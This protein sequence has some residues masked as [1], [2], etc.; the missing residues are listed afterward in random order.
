MPNF[1]KHLDEFVG[2]R[3]LLQ[4]TLEGC[5]ADLESSRVEGLNIEAAQVIIQQVSRETQEQ[6]KFHI[7]SIVSMALEAV[8]DEPYKFKVLFE[9]KRNQTEA[10]CKFERDGELI[11]PMTATGG[12][13][14]DVASF[15]L[16]VTLW[17][18]GK[19]RST[20]IL[21]EPF[22]F[23]SQD[24][25]PRAGA[26]I[27]ELSDKLGIQ[28]IVVTHSQIMV[29]AADKVLVARLKNGRSKVKEQQ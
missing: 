1:R 12:G 8:F 13:A 5:V 4:R 9:I 22:R 11:D 7:E 25:Q 23:V 16:R 14:V 19:T 2:E 20:I 3:N 27:K 29:D 17:S 26:L 18:L 6:L 15:A 28:F 24:L 21:D 10:V